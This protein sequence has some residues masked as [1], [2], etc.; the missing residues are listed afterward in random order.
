MCHRCAQESVGMISERPIGPI[1]QRL[2][3]MGLW[4]VSAPNISIQ[5]CLN[6]LLTLR[7]SRILVAGS[8][9][10]TLARAAHFITL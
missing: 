2:R 10:K 1:L 6:E 8:L 9:L 4:D 3:Y 7:S 5:I